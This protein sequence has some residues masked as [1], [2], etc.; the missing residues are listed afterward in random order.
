MGSAGRSAN[1]SLVW[2]DTVLRAPCSWWK[3]LC[4]LHVE[5]NIS[6]AAC[7]TTCSFT[8]WLLIPIRKSSVADKQ[9]TSSSWKCSEIAPGRLS[10]AESAAEPSCLQEPEFLARRTTKRII[11]GA[12]QGL[13]SAENLPCWLPERGFPSR[14][15]H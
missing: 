15:S 3:T 8:S 13:Q 2:S 7:K 5:G 6:P 11:K 14:R 12:G 10:G 9:S 1:A 4:L